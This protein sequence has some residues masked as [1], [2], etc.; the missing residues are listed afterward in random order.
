MCLL[1]LIDHSIDSFLSRLVEK[2]TFLDLKDG[3]K[4][5]IDLSRNKKKKRGM[6]GYNLFMKEK[7]PDIV[8]EN[9]KKSFG[10]ISRLVAK[11][12]NTLPLKEKEEYKR[13]AQ[14]WNK[15]QQ[16]QLWQHYIHKSLK[17]IRHIADN[18]FEDHPTVILQEDLTKEDILELLIENVHLKEEKEEE[19]PQS[20]PIGVHPYYHYLVKKSVKDLCELCRQHFGS[21]TKWETKTRQEL[22]EFLVSHFDDIAEPFV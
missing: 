14:K 10:D 11:A 1:P 2:Y 4:I 3:K 20:E 12:W 13:R 19:E 5:W 6:H 16:E 18:W 17:Y 9:K 15:Y 22:V 21:Q 7:R 8:K